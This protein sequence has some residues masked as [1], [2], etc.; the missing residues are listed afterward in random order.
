MLKKSPPKTFC[1]KRIKMR[2]RGIIGF[3]N[4]DVLKAEVLRSS[5]DSPTKCC[6][7]IFPML[8]SKELYIMRV[9]VITAVGHMSWRT[10]VG[11]R[12]FRIEVDSDSVDCC[13]PS[14]RQVLPNTPRLFR[15][16]RWIANAPQT[17]SN[18]NC[19]RLSPFT[20][21]KQWF[22]YTQREY[23]RSCREETAL[24]RVTHS[25]WNYESTSY[26]FCFILFWK[27]SILWYGSISEGPVD[28]EF[29]IGLEVCW[30]SCL[31]Y[32]MPKWHQP[33]QNELLLTVVHFISVNCFTSYFGY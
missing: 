13:Q 15:F 23:S 9:Y 20:G 32:C 8:C 10:S 14:Q 5:R 21:I 18:D 19:C 22:D 28:A 25:L 30:I 29:G 16:P 2:L 17:V 1:C 12:K 6:D 11:S 3:L 31:K 27:T 33:L 4:W 24:L 7:S 26:S